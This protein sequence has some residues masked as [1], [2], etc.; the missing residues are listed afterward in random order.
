MSCRLFLIRFIVLLFFARYCFFGRFVAFFAF[1]EVEV[2][3][4]L[5][6]SSIWALFN[7]LAPFDIKFSNTRFISYNRPTNLSYQCRQRQ[8]L[9]FLMTNTLYKLIMHI[10]TNSHKFLFMVARRDD[11]GSH[12]EYLIFRDQ[13]SLGSRARDLE[14]VSARVQ[15]W[16]DFELFQD[17]IVIFAAR[18][19][20]VNNSPAN[21]VPQ[22]GWSWKCDFEYDI[23][24]EGATVI[25]DSDVLKGE[26]GG[27]GHC[28]W[29]IISI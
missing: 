18:R 7:I 26:L 12:A 17:L 11:D 3:T 21:G 13:V 4:L 22:L 10:V 15:N 14:F 28:R 2:Q 1:G 6:S 5:R 16:L 25:F 24:V 8:M 19:P 9:S 23:G 29:R 20:H 27:W